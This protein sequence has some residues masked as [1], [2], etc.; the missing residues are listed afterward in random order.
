MAS[1]VAFQKVICNSE[2]RVQKSATPLWTPFGCR[3]CKAMENL[4][5]VD[6]V[7]HMHL[8]GELSPHFSSLVKEIHQSPLNT[9][10]P[11]WLFLANHGHLEDKFWA[12]LAVHVPAS[13]T[14]LWAAAVSCCQRWGP[15]RSL[16]LTGVTILRQSKGKLSLPVY[17]FFQL[18]HL[19]LI[20]FWLPPSGFFLFCRASRN[21]L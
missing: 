19:Q 8:K 18:F 14:I 5:S 13:Y 3:R 17:V 11:W 1:A 2:K 21:S 20:L 10:I 12:H 7:I 15:G 4:S 9:K 16:A 6:R